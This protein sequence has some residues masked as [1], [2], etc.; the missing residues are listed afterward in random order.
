MGKS[1]LEPRVLEEVELYIDHYLKPQLGKPMDM[2]NNLSKATCNI[3]SQMTLAKRFDYEDKALNDIMYVFSEGLNVTA[4]NGLFEDLPFSRIFLQSTES[5]ERN[6]YDTIIEPFFQSYIDE[7][8][9]TIEREYPRDV[10]DRYILHSESAEAEKA[11]SFSGMLVY[12][13]V[14]L[15]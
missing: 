6:M 2:R 7:H 9:E 15:K 4:R 11:V 12:G 8:K 14:C 13:I 5:F 1:A 3:I 10:T